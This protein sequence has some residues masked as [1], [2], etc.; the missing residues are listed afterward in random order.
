MP[1][2]RKAVLEAAFPRQVELRF[3]EVVLLKL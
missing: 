3:S 2:A 1:L